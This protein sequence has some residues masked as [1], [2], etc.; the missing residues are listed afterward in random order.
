MHAKVK[1]ARRCASCSCLCGA[2]SRP[3]QQAGLLRG[4]D[5]GVARGARG[6]PQGRR[7]LAHGGGPLWLK[8]GA[9]RFG[10]DEGQRHRPPRVGPAPGGRLRF[11]RRKASQCNSSRAWPRRSTGGSAPPWRSFALT[12][13]LGGGR[14][15]ARPPDDAGDRAGRALRDPPEGHAERARKAFAGLEWFPIKEAYRVTARFVPRPPTIIQ[16]PNVLGQVSE[17]PRPGYLV[18][19]LD[20]R[21]MRLDPVIEE[22]GANGAL[23]HLPRRDGPEGDLRRRALPVRGHAEG[24]SGRP[25][26]QQGLQPAVRLHALRDVPA[27]AEAEPSAASR[28]EAG[29]LNP[30]PGLQRFLAQPPQAHRTFRAAEGVLSLIVKRPRTHRRPGTNRPSS[31]DERRG[32]P[33]GEDRA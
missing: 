22:P 18:F 32:S 5:P 19:T 4:R 33:Q 24:R 8:E 25:R 28:I 14:P 13:G 27:A 10:S 2:C 3:R 1:Q 20:G 12:P 17:M 31:G 29:E 9:N 30:T 23:H 6:T 16:V 7:R 15:D 21:S 26:L 11:P